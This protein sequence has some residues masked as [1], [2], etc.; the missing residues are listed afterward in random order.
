VLLHDGTHMMFFRYMSK[1]ATRPLVPLGRAPSQNY[2]SRRGSIGGCFIL[3]YWRA[4]WPARLRSSPS[5]TCFCLDWHRHFAARHRYIRLIY[6]GLGPQ[7]NPRG[8][9]DRGHEL[10]VASTES[11]DAHERDRIA[12]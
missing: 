6:S 5:R 2:R 7:H 12:D 3:Q 9:K 10:P 4:A 8:S 11:L 1:P